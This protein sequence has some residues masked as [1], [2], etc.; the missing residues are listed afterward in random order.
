MTYNVFSGTLNPTH[1]TSLHLYGQDN[2]G[3]GSPASRTV[4]ESFILGMWRV[5]DIVFVIISAW[6]GCAVLRSR[7]FVCLPGYL[8]NTRP[9]R[10]S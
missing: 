8:K 4:Y 1:F 7:M 3:F 9:N 2:D 6:K 5:N 10:T